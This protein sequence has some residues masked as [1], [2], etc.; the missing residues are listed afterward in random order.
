MKKTALLVLLFFVSVAVF[1]QN[2]IYTSHEFIDKQIKINYALYK[3]GTVSLYV[4]V[5][6]GTTFNGPLACL[7]GDAGCNIKPGP[8]RSMIWDAP[9]G[10]DQ[11]SPSLL[12]FKVLVRDFNDISIPMVNVIGGTFTIGNKEH[13]TNNIPSDEVPVHTA[14]VSDF[15][16]SKYEITQEQWV[17]IMGSNPSFFLGDSLPVDN[18]SYADVRQFVFKLSKIT[19]KKY[20]MPTEAEWLYAARGGHKSQGYKYSGSNNLDEVAWTKE[21]SGK[22]THEV[23]TKEPNEL[24]IYDMTG[25]VMEWCYDNYGVYPSEDVINPTGP[26]KET[27]S[28]YKDGVW[29][30]QEANKE[31]HYVMKG[32]SWIN[33]SKN[34]YLDKR[35]HSYINHRRYNFGVRIVME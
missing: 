4:S 24:G 21:N 33:S 2:A 3:E 9:A 17:T 7:S 23:G 19:G 35:H 26:I 34:C 11:I 29:T 18:V 20:R 31:P 14:T 5:D 28:T 1:A 16:I 6:G 8:S 12:Q 13:Q 10:Y 22:K 32:A 15:S 25:N 27:L 30:I